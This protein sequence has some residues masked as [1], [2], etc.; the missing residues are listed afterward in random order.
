MYVRVRFTLSDFFGGTFLKV[1]IKDTKNIRKCAYCMSP[2]ER[3]VC[4]SVLSFIDVG[5]PIFS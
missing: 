1:V 4:G 2:C 3:H 5:C